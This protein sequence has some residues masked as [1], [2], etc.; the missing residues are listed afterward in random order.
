MKKYVGYMYGAAK[1]RHIAGDRNSLLHSC[2]NVRSSI[3]IVQ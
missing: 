3:F 2:Q 1:L